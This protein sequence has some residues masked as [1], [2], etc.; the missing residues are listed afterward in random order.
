MKRKVNKMDD[1]KIKATMAEIITVGGIPERPYYTIR[2]KQLGK[3]DFDIGFGSYQKKYVEEYLETYFE[4]YNFEEIASKLPFEERVKVCSICERHNTCPR[5]YDSDCRI[6][7]CNL[8]EI[9]E[10]TEIKEQ[11]EKSEEKVVQFPV[12]MDEM[13]RNIWISL[14]NARKECTDQ[15]LLTVHGCVAI[16]D[17]LFYLVSY[18]NIH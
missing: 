18:L 4:I 3:E 16:I 7:I 10:K 2:Y 6:F 5:L 17:A 11:K 8:R 12:D 1:K 9:I 15:N 13:Q 14:L